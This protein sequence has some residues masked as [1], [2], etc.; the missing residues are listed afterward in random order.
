MR[1]AP[2]PATSIFAN[3]LS[4]NS[5]AALPRGE[6]LGGDRRRPVLAGP[7]A[8]PDGLERAARSFGLNQFGRSQPDFSPKTAPRSCQPRVRRRQSKRPA[9]LALLVRVVDVVVRRV[10]LAS[11]GRAC[12]PGSGTG[13]RTVGCPSSRGRAPVRRRRSTDATW[14]PIPPAPAIPWAQNPAATKN[15]RTSLS[16]RMNSLSG[17]K[18]LGAVDDPADAGVGDRRHAPDRAGHDLLEPR[19]VGGQELAVEVRR[20]AVER[21]RRRVPL[22]AAHAQPA[23]LLAEVARGCPGRA[24]GAGP[25]ARPRSPR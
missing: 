24:A 4:S 3:E 23:D 20:D 17:V 9:G 10:D 21:P 16:P 5:P 7:A 15:P 22:V 1:S 12:T 8:R 14:R 19:P 11:S 25:R 6:R 13:R 2:G 18:R